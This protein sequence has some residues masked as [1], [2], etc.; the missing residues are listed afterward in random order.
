MQVE[1]SKGA[2][3]GRRGRRTRQGRSTHDAALRCRFHPATPGELGAASTEGPGTAQAWPE[4]APGRARTSPGPTQNEVVV[5]GA[6]VAVAVTVVAVVVVRRRRSPPPDGPRAP[7]PRSHRE[8]T[9]G[10]RRGIAMTVQR[11]GRATLQ[12]CCAASPSAVADRRSNATE[13]E[14][15]IRRPPC[16]PI[17]L[18][19]LVLLLPALVPL[20]SLQ[21]YSSTF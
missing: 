6:A 2:R 17:R 13:C 16:G 12:N 11:H 21:C 5:V 18:R 15:V 14:P 20:S 7:H 10:P 3:G 19:G 4:T 9:K 1:K 8:V